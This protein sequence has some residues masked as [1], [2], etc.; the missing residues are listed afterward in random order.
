MPA[1]SIII[2][3]YGVE[4]YI[5]KCARSLF[6]QTLEDI[7]Y[8][9]VDDCTKDKSIE[10]LQQVIE[11]Y[12]NRKHQT[13]IIHHETNR[14]LPQARKTGIENSTGEYIAHCDSDDW[15]DKDMYYTL[16]HKAESDNCD[17][18]V[19]DLY[20]T[21]EQT[22]NYI[23]YFPQKQLTKD[24]LLSNI[25]SNTCSHYFVTI[26]Y[27]RQLI[28]NPIHYPTANLFEDLVFTTQILYYAKK[29]GY[30]QKPLYHYI[31]RPTSMSYSQ[32]LEQKRKNL[33]PMKKNIDVILSFLKENNIDEKYEKIIKFFHNLNY[34][35][36]IRTRQQ[37]Q[38]Y[39]GYNYAD[40][41]GG[42]LLKKEYNILLK[43]RYLLVRLK[44]FRLYDWLD[45][46]ATANPWLKNKLA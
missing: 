39:A 32:T 18:V 29:I 5:E 23:H 33:I 30:V 12:P 22:S 16:Y 37:K 10:I 36:L 44:L 3:I 38:Q 21:Q 11:D 27:Q 1:V 13:K 42:V 40:T 43:I 9:F 35:T 41:S 6:E 14:G 24:S 4:Q 26:L 20:K 31:L 8:I 45:R 34:Q 46:Q 25:F 15:V 19:C 2:P 7:E 17:A 28:N